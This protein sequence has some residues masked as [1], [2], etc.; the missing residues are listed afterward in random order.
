MSHFTTIKTQVKDLDLMKKVLDEL[1]YDYEFNCMIRNYYDN[2][3]KVN[4]AI[5]I[6]SEYAVGLKKNQ[7]DIYEAIADWGMILN[8]QPWQK[9]MQNYSLEVVKQQAIAMGYEINTVEVNDNDEIRVVI[10]GWS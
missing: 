1:K 8:K 7:D 6:G 4:L 5:N 3:T 2:Q 10:E 9:I